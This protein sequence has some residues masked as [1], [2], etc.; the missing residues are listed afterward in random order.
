MKEEIIMQAHDKD[1]T[2][3]QMEEDAY[4]HCC[5]YEETFEYDEDNPSLWADHKGGHFEVILFT[6]KLLKGKVRL[7]LEEIE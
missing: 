2:Q 3:E 4:I 6:T 5:R 1:A 7:T